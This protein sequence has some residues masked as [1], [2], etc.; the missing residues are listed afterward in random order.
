MPVPILPAFKLNPRA[1]EFKPNRST[2]CLKPFGSHGPII[3]DAPKS[4]MIPLLVFDL[5]LNFL[6]ECET[7]FTHEIV[8]SPPSP[9]IISPAD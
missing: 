4:R 2:T 5:L 3:R 9:R 1:K 6:E 7:P 8:G